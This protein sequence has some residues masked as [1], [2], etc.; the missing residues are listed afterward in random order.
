MGRG[1]GSQRGGTGC[2]PSEDP[3]RNLIYHQGPPSQWNPC[4]HQCYQC[5]RL[6]QLSLPCPCPPFV[7][8]AL[9]FLCVSLV[10]PSSS[11]CPHLTLL[12]LPCP[13]PYPDPPLPLPSPSLLAQ[14]SFLLW[15]YRL[16]PAHIQMSSIISKMSFVASCPNQNP[17]QQHV[18]QM[19]TVS[20]LLFYP[21][22]PLPVTLT[23]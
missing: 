16:S 6:H 12:P 20:L 4:G 14:R 7:P 19:V 15:H 13:W 11:P 8:L 1:Q 23:A 3:P 2:P 9:S 22:K 18:L 10:P 17:I 21:E 5:C